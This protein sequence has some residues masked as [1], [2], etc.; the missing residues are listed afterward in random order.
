MNTMFLLS[1]LK[2]NSG[3]VAK[4]VVTVAEAKV[5]EAAR[6]DTKMTKTV[7]EVAAAVVAAA[8]T[9][10]KKEEE[11]AEAETANHQVGTTTVNTKTAAN[12]IVPGGKLLVAVLYLKKNFI[13]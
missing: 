8:V 6:A 3:G 7:V 10:A 13:C 4:T 5:G 2:K 12:G 11:E 1:K 9:A